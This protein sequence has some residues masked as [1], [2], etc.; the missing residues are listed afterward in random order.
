MSSA[1]KIVFP[2]QPVDRYDSARFI[3]GQIFLQ[4]RRVKGTIFANVAAV[5]VRIP[6][7]Q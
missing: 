1:I 3:A 5:K 2:W 4:N 6:I 7:S